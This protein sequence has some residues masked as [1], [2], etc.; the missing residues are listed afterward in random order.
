MWKNILRMESQELSIRN[1]IYED[2]A[3]IEL[4]AMESDA[5]CALFYKISNL[6]SQSVN[7]KDKQE[8]PSI[9]L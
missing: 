3:R 6:K 2:V 9:K 1:R 5:R 8:M 7:T 4:E